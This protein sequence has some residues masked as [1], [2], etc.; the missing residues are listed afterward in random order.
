MAPL[1]AAG[2]RPTESVDRLVFDRAR[3]VG[4]EVKPLE[5]IQ[6]HGGAP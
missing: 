1:D 2:S 5:A 6:E 4:R 3:V